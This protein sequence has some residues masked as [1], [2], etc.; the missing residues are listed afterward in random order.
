MD[1]IFAF[2][3]VLA[4]SLGTTALLAASGKRAG[5]QQTANARL[6]TDGAFRDGLYIGRLTAEQRRPSHPLIGRWSSEKD[7][8]SFAAGYRRGYTEFL[9]RVT[10]EQ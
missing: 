1:K 5:Q 7:R 2:A 8:T 10:N 9:A 6:A 3:L 4:V